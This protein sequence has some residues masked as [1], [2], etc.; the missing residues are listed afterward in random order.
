M[1]RFFDLPR[2]LRDMIYREVLM[3]PAP[4]PSL[5]DIQ[6]ASHWQPIHQTHRATPGFRCSISSREIPGTCASILACNRQ[7]N[8]EMTLIV[9]KER[10]RQQ[11]AARLDCAV[12]GDSHYFTWLAIPFVRPEKSNAAG[13]QEG[14]NQESW[15]SKAITTWIIRSLGFRQTLDENLTG[16]FST[17]LD[18]SYSSIER[19]WVDVRPS[20]ESGASNAVEAEIP[21]R[22]MTSWAICAAL[23]H[24]FD[25]GP[26]RMHKNRRL[27]YIDEVIINILPQEPVASAN[28]PRSE[29]DEEDTLLVPEVQPTN[30]T[31][32]L[33]DELVNVWDKI[34]SATD[35]NTSEFKARLYRPLLEKIKRVRICVGGVTFR[36][37][38]LAIELERG[39]AEMRRIQMR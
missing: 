6:S 33:R 29:G 9:A 30:P 19:L 17:S 32:L 14:D 22:D 24:I 37:R 25:N 28:T 26:D 38:G 31:E 3:S 34:W 27:K 13:Q 7:I 20:S 23:K 35:A 10:R 18:R 11:L 36:T 8:E 39:R 12:K 1:A 4:R 2:E 5:H 21:R 15:I 16:P